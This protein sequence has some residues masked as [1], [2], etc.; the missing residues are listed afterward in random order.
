MKGD[1]ALGEVSLPAAG[2]PLRESGLYT[3]VAFPR[4]PPP[5]NASFRRIFSASRSDLSR[6][7]SARSAE[8]PLNV[9]SWTLGVGRWK[10]GR[11]VA[12]PIPRRSL[13][14]FY[15]F[16][17]VKRSGLSRSPCARSAEPPLRVESWTLDV[18]SLAARSR[19]RRPR[20]APFFEFSPT[21]FS[22][23]LGLSRSGSL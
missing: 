2:A 12:T 19:H 22:Q 3:R 11:A 14:S 15:R 20:Y 16:F 1:G 17:P 4:S 13:S 7:P 5:E 8:P 21:F 23:A 10:F 6:S 18:E 9:E